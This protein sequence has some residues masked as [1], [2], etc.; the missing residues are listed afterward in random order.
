MLVVITQ[1]NSVMKILNELQIFR[2]GCVTSLSSSCSY[3]G[4]LEG[5]RCLAVGYFVCFVCSS[6]KHGLI[7]RNKAVSVNFPYIYSCMQSSF[8]L[9]LVCSP[10]SI[11]PYL[12][13]SLVTCERA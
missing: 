5:V 7:N 13:L 8:G 10:L 3:P 2:D 4:L 12:D 11:K 9:Q 6:I 1:C